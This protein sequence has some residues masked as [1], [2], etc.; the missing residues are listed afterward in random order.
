MS[1]GTL[2][3]CVPNFSEGRRP[4]VLAALAHAA[5]TVRDVQLLAYEADPDHNRAVFTLAGS[6]APLVHALRAMAGTALRL[7]DLNY[8]QG[9][10]PRIGALDVAPFVPL[11]DTPISQA[12]E[13]AERAGAL[14]AKDLGLPC[15]LYGEAARLPSRRNLAEVR[16]LGFE[17]LRDRIVSEPGLAPDFGPS[18]VHPT[19][20]AVA[21]GAREI[22]IAF[23]VLLDTQD[24]RP[25][26][27]IAHKIRERDGGLPAVRALGLPLARLGC[28]QVSMNLVDYRKT[29]LF[30]AFRRVQA[31]AQEMGVP[32]R[33][34]EMIGMLP[35]A[36]LAG[37]DLAE[38]GFVDFDPTERVLEE[39]L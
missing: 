14:L 28:V 16:N 37:G 21:V 4:E 9:V 3:E 30:D 15:Y 11:G 26:K 31:L 39:K 33:G 35:Q 32:V 8:H 29:G 22:L 6:L 38:L 17:A 19:A 13:A 20:G 7:I 1:A 2:L 24:L 36:A 12:I 25:A 34:S 18:Q 10:H 23:N 5:G 27:A